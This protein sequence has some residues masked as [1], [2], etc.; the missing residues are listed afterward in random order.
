MKKRLFIA[1]T[2][3]E[4]T[5]KKLFNSLTGVF[6]DNNNFKQ[7]PIDNIHLTLKFIGDFEEKNLNILKKTV[8]QAVEGFNA[9]YFKIGNQINAFPRIDLARIVFA[10]VTE[11]SDEIFKLFNLLENSLRKL[12]IKKEDKKFTAHITLARI[13]NFV[14]LKDK[15]DFVKIP[16]IE[17]LICKK[18]VLFESILNQSGAKYIALGEFNL[19]K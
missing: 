3:P 14:N 5:R 12:K 19:K 16:N 2:L 7:I 13:K 10:P 11:G 18:I 9:F 8:S 6:L 15:V 1:I 4:D 17:P